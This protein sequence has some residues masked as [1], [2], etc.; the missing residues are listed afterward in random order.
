MLSP[1][2]FIGIA[3]AIEPV[4]QPA[5]AR[6]Q[7]ARVLSTSPLSP[8]GRLPAGPAQSPPGATATPNSSTAPP[9]NLPR[10][11]LLDI[12]V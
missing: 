7:P 9:R 6:V 11:S 8:L 3:K 2:T 12:S 1:S 10:G 5:P 4:G